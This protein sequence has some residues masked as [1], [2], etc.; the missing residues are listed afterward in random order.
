MKL[1]LSRE[2][3]WAAMLLAII[4]RVF[5]G[6][7]L[8]VP[9]HNGAWLAVLLGGALAMPV[10]IG[11][12]R[13]A[14]LNGGRQVISFV[15]LIL[16]LLDGGQTARTI[17]LSASYL[18]LDQISLIWLVVP[19][20]VAV[21]WCMLH[22]GDAIGYSAQVW[23]KAFPFLLIVVLAMQFTSLQP[24]WLLPLL[25]SNAL[26]IVRESLRIAGWIVIPSGVL[27][28][29][30]PLSSP[31]SPRKTAKTVV[32]SVLTTVV[33]VIL[34][35]MLIPTQLRE[36]AN[37][38]VG[39]LDTFLTNGREPLYLQLPLII[40]WFIGTLHVFCLEGFMAAALLQRLISCLNKYVA[41][42]FSVAMIAILQ[43]LSIHLQLIHIAYLPYP[44]LASALVFQG[45]M[46]HFQRGGRSGCAK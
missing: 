2:A 30:E 39:R 41:V 40:M 11:F 6:V 37:T 25:G 35:Q 18:A 44:L 24:A 9:F 8:E 22:G 17:A 36:Y 20:Y 29:A 31:D 5:V 7:T 16:T 33:L 27:T 3:A 45:L 21:I 15:L 12:E 4:A 32:Y 42:V 28:L 38:H 10:I 43:F 26:G 14:G 23:I 34:R 1:S 46:D 13:L 19:I